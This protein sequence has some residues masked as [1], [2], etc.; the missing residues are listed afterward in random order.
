MKGSNKKFISGLLALGTLSSGAAYAQIPADVAGTGFEE[1]IQVLAALNIMI[2]DGNGKFRP[3]D[4]LTRAEVAKLAIHAMGID[5]AVN[6]SD[7]SK[8]PDVSEDYWAKGYINLAT[9]MGIVIG[10][11]NGNFRPFDPITYAEAMTI[12]VRATGYTPSAEQKGGF[13]SGYILVGSENGM[14]KNVSG[15]G[16]NPITRGS[17]AYLTLNTL[18]TNMMEQ[19]NYGGNVKY[20][21]GTKTLLTD[22]HKVTELTGQVKAIATS[23]IDGASTLND[24]QVKIDDKIYDADCNVSKLLGY[25][26]TFYLKDN[27]K[28][29]ESVILA[30]PTEG[31]NNAVTIDSDLFDKVTK[32]NS[33][34]AISYFTSENSSKTQT[35]ELSPSAALI[36]NGRHSAL[37]DSLLDLDGK[38]AEMTLLD[39][40]KD[41]KYDFVFV[42]SFYSMVVDSVTSSGKISDKNSSKTITLDDDVTYTISRGVENIKVSDLAEYDVLSV[43]ESAD[44]KLYEIVAS[45]RTVSGKVSSISNGKYFIGSDGYKL[46]PDF[47]GELKVGTEATFYL[48]YKNNIVSTDSFSSLSSDYGYMTR[49]YYVDNDE[50]VKFKIFDK[51]GTEKLYEGASKIKLNGNGAQKDQT[52]LKTILGGGEFKAQLVTFKLNEDGK[53]SEINTAKDNSSTGAVDKNSFTLNYS[54]KNTAYNAS[55]EKLG[56]VKITD[57][58]V[59]FDIPAGSEDYSVKDKSM[60][61]DKQKY[62]ALIFDVTEDLTARAVIV[63]SSELSTN[64]SESI[65]VVKEISQ[66]TNSDDEISDVLVALTNGSETRIFA[67]NENVLKKTDG[68]KLKSGDI[69]QIK[70]NS[71]GEIASIRVLFDSENADEEFT[72]APAEDLDVVYGKVTKKFA[73]SINVTVNGGSA[74][75]YSIPSDALV[76]KVDT[77]ASK[78]SVS[79]A[80]TSDIQVYDADDESRV[81]IRLYKNAVKEIVIVE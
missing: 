59:I 4:N 20:E 42:T 78:N 39:T 65:A 79:T 44:K 27:G 63:T 66:G 34:K 33:N 16:H 53:V 80:K 22:R 25:N 17:V 24:G 21:V 15:S 28:G 36:Y 18:K 5:S 76:Y 81:F 77:K 45:N 9:S 51:N 48:D 12:M 13:P 40:D 57:E 69:I 67:E 71:S 26:V 64:A 3:N 47:K 29:D 35:A 6:S 68:K 74:V 60:F 8:F 43:A 31:K 10:D 19:T 14:N 54:L 41:G 46:S 1:P 23:A 55:N 52:V 62:S 58:T 37:D 72:K 49:A 2:G 56:N 70:K 38:T 73:S 11:D 61:E 50:V 7:Q 75:N 30:L 32:K